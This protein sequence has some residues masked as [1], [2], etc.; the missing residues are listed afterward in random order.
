MRNMPD[1]NTQIRT[2]LAAGPVSS[3]SLR[4]TLSITRPTLAR[5]LAEMAGEIVTLGAA[6]ATQYALRDSFRGLADIPVYRVNDA[7]QIKHLGQLC[8]VRPGGFVVLHSDSKTDY[9]EGLPWWLADMRP[10]GFLGRA[11][12]RQHASGLGLPPDVRHW[13]DTDAL[14]A[15]VANGGDAV[16]NLLLGDLA[17][18]RFVNAP[19]PAAVG[20]DVY[21]RLAA[22]ALTVGDTWSS[23][24]GEQPKFCAYTDR[25]HVL[26][27]FTVAGDNAIA[28]RTRDLLL[29]EHLALET[30]AA[31]GVAAAASQWVDVNV[32]VGVDVAGVQRFLELERFDRVGTHG[33]HALFSL[34]CLDGEFVGNATAP[35]PVVTCE[36]AKQKRI[37]ERAHAGATL[38]YAFGT[39]IANTDMHAGNLSFVGDQGG[40]FEL[41]P[42]YDMLPM[43]FAPSAGG[44][45][46]DTLPAAHLHASVDGETWRAAL[47][48][49]K[50]YLVR[51]STEARWSAGF[52]PCI[53]ALHGH[54]DNAVQKITRL[55]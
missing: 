25:G 22:Q 18:E 34:A 21:P 45:M 46:R 6:R 37:T 55:G 9:Y 24:G 23:A 28:A 14:R 8:P 15:L 1:R 10:Q 30:L 54:V 33:R 26:V 29:A 13:S 53:H 36:L 4:T 38:L 20:A 7:G 5:A 31:G 19:A 35:W 12:A 2:A 32:G 27:K 48:L 52:Q 51:L 44:V 11:Y 41:S 42:A 50:K 40:P 17:R 49:A 39:L 3:A 43:A 47:G 16:G